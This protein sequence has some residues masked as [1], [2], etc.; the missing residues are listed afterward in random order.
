MIEALLCVFCFLTT[1]DGVPYMETAGSY[2]SIWSPN[3]EDISYG[4][5]AG[6]T[7]VGGM[8]HTVAG[9]FNGHAL[10]GV[11]AQT[12]GVATEA[13]ARQGS[14]SILVGLESLVGNYEPTNNS[15]KIGVNIVY[16]SNVA[17]NE[18][19][20]GLWFTSDPNTGFESAIKLDRYSIFHSRT[21][22]AAVIDLADMDITQLKD[23]DL[24]RFPNCKAMRWDGEALKVVS[25]C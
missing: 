18:N 1:P 24:I 12:W 21:K 11:N 13:V 16:K 23:V 15:A 8:G 5:A 2:R 6:V 25:I 4:F 19:S 9:Q 7:R 14:K 22:R 3:R 17:A 10:S 20:V